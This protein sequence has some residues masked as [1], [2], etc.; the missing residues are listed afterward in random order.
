MKTSNINVHDMLSVWSVEEVEKR[1]GEVLGVESV[2]LNYASATATVRYDETLLHVADIK[3]AV[4]QKSYES[5]KSES[6]TE[7]LII[8]SPEEKD[9]A[10]INPSVKIENSDMPQPSPMVDKP[11][12]DRADTPATQLVTEAP[13]EQDKA[14]IKPPVKTENADVPPPSPM[15]DKPAEEKAKLT[16][17]DKPEEEKNKTNA[18]EPAT[19]D[20]TKMD[21]SKMQHGSNPAMGH[22]GHNHQ[23]MID[24]FKK[25]FYVVL[26]LT[27]PIMLLSEMIQQF[28]GVDWQFS[29]SNYLLFALSTIVF[30]YGGWPFLKGLVDEVK[31]KNPGMMF[32][33]GF[34]ITVAYIYS[35]AIVFGLKGMDFFWELATLIL[36]MLLGHWIEMKSVAGASKELELLVQLMPADAHMVM[37]DKVH[38]V[39]TDTLKANDIILKKWRLTELFWKENLI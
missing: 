13:E 10:K 34:A 16:S 37:P 33:I 5:F 35:V 15:E 31:A 28:I 9:K 14:E 18:G 30:F 1:I 7:P 4:R 8:D 38:D 3:S 23:A 11:T 21:H 29:G 22:E 2:T 39:K 32:L 27:I 6:P 17:V 12:E 36:I 19:M 24:D 26:A 20:H 25:R